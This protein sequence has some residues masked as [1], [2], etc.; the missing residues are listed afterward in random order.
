MALR[1][2]IGGRDPSGRVGSAPLLLPWLGAVLPVFPHPVPLAYAVY[3]PSNGS[4][5]SLI[6]FP[7]FVGVR[8][9]PVGD[10]NVPKPPR[11]RVHDLLHLSD[12]DLAVVGHRL[13]Q[14]FAFFAVIRP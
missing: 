7:L 1:E 9:L 13:L 3:E 12:L 11:W 14:L 8:R 10:P 4:R 6:L 2:Y 5:L